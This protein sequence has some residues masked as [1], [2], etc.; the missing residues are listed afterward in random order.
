MFNGHFSMTTWVTWHQKCKPFW[1]FLKQEMMGGSGISWTI[2]KSFA[3]HSRQK[4][5]SD[6]YWRGYASTHHS[7]FLRLDAL[8]DAQPLV[9]MH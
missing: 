1:I 8:S 7:F 6:G 3:P 9:S 4:K 2:R 5:M